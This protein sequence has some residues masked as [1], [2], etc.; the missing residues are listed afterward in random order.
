MQVTTI[1]LDLEKNIFQVHGIAADGNVAFSKSVSRAR[2]LQFFENLKPYLIGV[3]P[4][5]I[6]QCDLLPE[7]LRRSGPWK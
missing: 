6:Y 7:T 3:N 1:G 4:I 5:Q 2:L